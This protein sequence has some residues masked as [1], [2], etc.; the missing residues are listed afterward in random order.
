MGEWSKKIGEHGEGI[1]KKFLAKIGWLSPVSGETID[2]NYSV[3]H[4]RKKGSPR[5]THGI[6][7]LY[8][9][10]REGF[11][12]SYL[13]SVKYT[14]NNY[15]SSLSTDFKKHFKDL[16]Q[17]L[18]CFARSPL[19]KEI[20]RNFNITFSHREKGI[21]FW[22]S[23]T[24]SMDRNLALELDRLKGLSDESYGEI[25]LVD[26]F[27]A[28]FIFNSIEYVQNKYKDFCFEFYYPYA[29]ST[30]KELEQ[31]YSG[32]VLPVEFITS[33]V[34][35][36]K[37]EKNGVNKLVICINEAYDSESLELVFGMAISISRDLASNI[38]L[39]YSSYDQLKDERT[40]AQ[41][42]QK[43]SSSSLICNA[44]IGSFN[45]DFRVLED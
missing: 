21:L 40:V 14:S 39:L 38:V 19:K 30:N 37:L 27:Q 33:Q 10:L 18:V 23:S 1:V 45:S 22:L 28:S 41:I 9:E 4:E 8:S 36:F 32:R 7:Y 20:K 11:L 29:I 43:F 3:K 16:S 26:N 42:K 6:D 24:D 25:Y 17:T 31:V 12:D 34:L 5:T 15:P 13:I 44:E 2:C 35:T